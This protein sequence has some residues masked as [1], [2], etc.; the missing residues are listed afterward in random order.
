MHI[1]LIFFLLHINVGCEVVK[2]VLTYTT[3]QFPY[4]CEDKCPF[5]AEPKYYV[6][7]RPQLH[8]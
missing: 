4:R 8:H 6:C 3:L 1:E 2:Q 7:Q 5:L